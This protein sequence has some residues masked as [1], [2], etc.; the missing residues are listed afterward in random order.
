MLLA[1][2]IHDRIGRLALT[3]LARNAADAARA[4]EIGCDPRHVPYQLERAPLHVA[5]AAL[6]DWR[7]GWTTDKAVDLTTNE[8]WDEL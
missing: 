3:V 1:Y 2:S 4:A 8:G 5:R 6:A 7:S